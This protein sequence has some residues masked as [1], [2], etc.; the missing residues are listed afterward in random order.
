MVTS[1]RNEETHGDP[2]KKS[3]W[4]RKMQNDAELG[5][6]IKKRRA[7]SLTRRE[8]LRSAIRAAHRYQSLRI[9][10][11][12]RSDVAIMKK[13]LFASQTRREIFQSARM[14]QSD[15]GKP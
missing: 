1:A 14:A 10:D 9:L 11:M 4:R 12:R 7:A 3:A 5:L 15:K 8:M 13:R 6:I 2:Q